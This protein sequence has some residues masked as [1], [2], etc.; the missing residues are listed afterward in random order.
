MLLDGDLGKVLVYLV[1]VEECL[2]AGDQKD[3]SAAAG[4]LEGGL[5][6]GD[7][8]L[9]RRISVTA[10]LNSRRIRRRFLLMAGL[11]CLRWLVPV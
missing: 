1:L 11:Y 10:T 9:E 2:A 4:D 6:F 8:S 7:R 3:D 5:S